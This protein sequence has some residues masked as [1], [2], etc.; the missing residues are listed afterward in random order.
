MKSNKI[1]W[2]I[3][4]V[5]FIVIIYYIISYYKNE[6]E[7]KKRELRNLEMVSNYSKNINESIDKEN[8]SPISIFINN[9][10][11]SY[12]SGIFGKVWGTIIGKK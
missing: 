2:I 8:I 3:I 5:V 1:K 4:I 9:P 11:V 12:T 10:L 7:D 6:I